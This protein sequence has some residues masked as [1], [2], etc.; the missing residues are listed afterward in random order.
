MADKQWEGT[1]YGSSWMHRT[2][3]RILR[4]CDVRLLYV[5]S[6]VFVIPVCLVGR[7][8][9]GIIYRYFRQ[10]FNYS[11]LK[12]AWKSYVN[13][14]QFSEVVIDRFAMYAGKNFNIKVE[15]YEH[16]RKLAERPE[17]FVQLSAHVGNYEAAGYNLKAE[18]KR[19]NALVFSG[20]KDSVMNNR[21]KM[22]AE[23]N[24]RMIPVSP[25]MSHLFV[26]DKALCDGETLSMPADRMFGSNKFVE[27]EFLG[28]KARFPMGPFSVPTMLGL[29]VLAV[30]GMKTSRKGYTI[31]VTPLTYDKTLPRKQQ[32]LDLAQNYVKELENIVRRYPT[33][34][35]NYFEFWNT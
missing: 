10:R 9:G 14:C 33:Q 6:A 28:A 31:F 18:Q 15:G 30:N 16:F 11:P 27:E 23:T 35:Y 32:M 2:L 13:H 29:D 8:G 25:D 5:F 26:I 4:L 1:T 12:A 19:F 24:I 3:I 20:E 7:P 22:F 17:G 21:N 34:W